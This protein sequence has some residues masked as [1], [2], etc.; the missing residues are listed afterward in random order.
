MNP[1]QSF[2][3]INTNAL[4]KMLKQV[5]HNKK[6]RVIPN[7]FRNLGFGNDKELNAFILV[8]PENLPL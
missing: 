5:Q 8:L 7:L 4:N 3:A 6:K 2:F 1:C